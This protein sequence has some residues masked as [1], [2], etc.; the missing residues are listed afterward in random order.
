ML[1]VYKSNLKQ[2][3]LTGSRIKTEA[4]L[5]NEQATRFPFGSTEKLKM[6]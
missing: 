2:H 1:T 4:V 6:I 5:F 3:V